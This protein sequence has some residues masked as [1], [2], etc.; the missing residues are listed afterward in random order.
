MKET[1]LGDFEETLLL[2][3]GILD[4]EAYAFKIAEEFEAQ[5]ETI[6]LDRCCAFYFKTG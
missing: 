3:V 5:T 1:R 6:Y 2:L 4:K